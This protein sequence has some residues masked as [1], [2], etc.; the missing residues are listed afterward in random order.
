MNVFGRHI[1]FTSFG[2]SHGTAIGG[3][4]D[5][6]K[7]GIHLS[8]PLIEEA[9]R[10]RQPQ[11]AYSTSRH[12]PDKI[13]WLSGV[14]TLDTST[15]MTLGS[16]IAFS[17]AN[18]DIRPSDYCDTARPGHADMTY[19][20]RY[21]IPQRSGGGRASARETVSRVVAG[22]IC[23]QLLAE[24]GI[25][26]FAYT[27][28]IGNIAVKQNY[29]E[30]NLSNEIYNN[31]LRCPDVGT[32]TAMETLL[33][34]VQA[35]DDSIGGIVTCVIQ[36][37]P[38][39]VGNPIFGKLPALLAGAMLSINACKGF[40]YGSGFEGVGKRGSELNDPYQPEWKHLNKQIPHT[41]TNN[42]GGCLGGISTGNDIYFRAVFKPAPS[43]GIGG[44]HDV[45]VV[46]RAV[47][48]VKAMTLLTL[49]DVLSDYAWN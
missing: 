27:S 36:G 47:S 6:I 49:A 7:A 35:H 28:A 16:P 17:I 1:T 4:L 10:H 45:C 43:I 29:T 5:G 9:V 30:F 48:V 25:N 40:D 13:S 33:S 44:R 2:E 41:L 20:L 14:E 21:G 34:N 23:E 46:P 31:N 24:H 38:A 26:V 32:R 39:G 18:T 8:L 15:L 22:A 42:A 12:E 3:V 19:Y 37:V 11:A